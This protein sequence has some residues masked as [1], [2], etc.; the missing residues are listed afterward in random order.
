M[1]SWGTFGT[2]GPP[3]HKFSPYEWYM[4]SLLVAAALSSCPLSWTSWL[5][6]LGFCLPG[7]LL[8]WIRVQWDSRSP[9]MAGAWTMGNLCIFNPSNHRI[10][11]VW[12]SFSFLCLFC[13]CKLFQAGNW[14][15]EN[16]IFFVYICLCSRRLVKVSKESSCQIAGW[17]KR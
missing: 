8:S 4:S 15:K 17:W 1:P 2:K 10:P 14:Q 5:L 7:T 11:F 16:T 12:P 9:S 3:A 13:Y 6:N